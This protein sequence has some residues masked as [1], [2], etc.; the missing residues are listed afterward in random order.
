MGIKSFGMRNLCAVSPAIR[1]FFWAHVGDWVEHAPQAFEAFSVL[2]SRLK[3]EKELGLTIYPS[4]DLVF[5]ALKECQ[6]EDVKAVVYGVDP[7]ANGCANGLA[8]DHAITKQPIAPALLRLL[9]KIKLDSSLDLF[10]ATDS[11]LSVLP[12]KGVLLLNLALTVRKGEPASHLIY[13][14]EFTALLMKTIATRTDVHHV[15]LGSKVQAFVGDFL[16]SS[17]SIFRGS[18]P[19][20]LSG[21]SFNTQNLFTWI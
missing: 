8:Y 6:F 16:S 12:R 5:R 21:P 15:L 4:E 7:Y 14:R 19:A 9:T 17:H 10:G 13:W 20:P 18:S 1:N 11:Y 2:A 3:H